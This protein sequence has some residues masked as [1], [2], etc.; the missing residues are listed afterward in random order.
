MPGYERYQQ[1]SRE[2]AGL[3][4]QIMA[5][6]GTWK[7][8]GQ[9]VEFRKAGK[10]W[11]YELATKALSEVTNP[12]PGGD[13]PSGRRPSGVERGRQFDLANSPD[14]KLKACYR[15]RNLW[16]SNADGTNEQALTTD[17][18]IAGRIKNGSASWVYGEELRQS[19][20]M[21][22]SP[23][24]SKLAY[25]RFDESPV[26]DYYLQLDQTRL[27]SKMDIEAYPK[28]GVNNPI[29][30]LFV[31]DLASKKSTKL[32]IRDGKPFTG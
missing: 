13:A 16:L 23:D 15:D 1:I 25:Y 29:V 10:L 22:W 32:D 8:N 19:S 6:P 9:A 14:G 2:M 7:D 5:V 30:A 24:G 26:P 17:G 27:Q 28:A 4:P 20:A 12:T 3:L 21:W 31:Y 18:S 11:R